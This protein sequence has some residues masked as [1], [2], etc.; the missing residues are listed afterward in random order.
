[1][2]LWLRLLWL[3]LSAPWR[4]RLPMPDGISE[5]TFRVLPNDLDLS[6]HMNNGRY[7]AIMDLGRLDLIVRIGLGRAVWR[8]G[9]TPVA[10]A[11]LVR[12][13]RELRAFERYRLET[14][15]VGWQD[16]AVLIEQS[17]IFAGGE[18]EGQVAARALF[19]GAL[20]D[21]RARRYVPVAEMMETI[22]ASATSP[23]VEADVEAFLAADRAMREAG[24]DPQGGA[25]A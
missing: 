22:G 24:R 8:N 9:W 11:A 25:G 13:R 15:V 5:L 19:K 16:Q 21:R 4:S 2:N 17:F 12:F 3:L 6:L 23:P 1:M 20:Y 18:R 7:L 14:R 10:N